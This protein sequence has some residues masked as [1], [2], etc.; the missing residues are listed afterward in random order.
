[1]VGGLIFAILSCVLYSAG[2]MELTFDETLKNVCMVMF[3]T[4]VGFQANLKV[5]KS[6]GVSLLIFLVCVTALIVRIRSEHE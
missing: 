3:F 5:L 2:V 6:G 1:M 4:S